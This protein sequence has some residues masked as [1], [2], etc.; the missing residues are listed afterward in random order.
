MKSVHTER[1]ILISQGDGYE[2]HIVEGREDMERKFLELHFGPKNL[3]DCTSV[4]VEA[5]EQ[6]LESLRNADNWMTNYALGP[7]SYE[8]NHED[9]NVYVYL[10]T[11]GAQR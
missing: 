11:D 3:T 2:T 5:M 10:L 8:V 7:V 1:W 9:G 4:D 6:M